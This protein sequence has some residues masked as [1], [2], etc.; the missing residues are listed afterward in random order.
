MLALSFTSKTPEHKGIVESTAAIIFLGTPHRGSPELSAIGEWARSMLSTLHFQTATAMLDTLGLKTTDLERAHEAFCRIWHQYDFQVKTFQESLGLTG[1]DLGVLGNKVVPHESSLIGDPREQA[2]TLQANHLQMCRFSRAQDPNYIKVAGE[3]RRFYIAIQN[4]QLKYPGGTK[5]SSDVSNIG[6]TPNTPL[7]KKDLNTFLKILHF[8]G[9]NTRRESILPP[10]ANT[11]EWLFHDPTSSQWCTSP[12]AADRLLF[13]KGKP[14]AGKSTLMKK[15]VRHIQAVLE[16]GI[17]ASFFVDA[18]GLPLQHSPKGIYQSLLCQ[19]L[20]L[21][22]IWTAS[23][24]SPALRYLTDTIRMALDDPSV[25]STEGQLQTL[26][27]DTLEV[28]SSTSTPI[29][30]F[31]DALDELELMQRHQIEFWRG[32]VFSTKSQTLRVCLSCRHFPNVAVN[33]CLELVLD[34]CNSQDIFTYTKDRLESHVSQSEPHW[35]RL[36]EKR[37]TSLASGVFL[38]VV[39]VL[40]DILAKYDQGISLQALMRHVEWMPTELEK[41]YTRILG[42]LAPN[43]GQLAEKVFQ[44]VFASTRPLR[45]DEWHHI[46]A[47]MRPSRPLSLQEWRESDDFTESDE[48]LERKIKTL[49]KGLLEVSHKLSEASNGKFAEDSSVNAGA[50]SLD[51]EQG[52]S[53]VV[54]AIHQSVYDFFIHNQGFALFGS[55]SAN[56]L[57]DCHCTIANTCLNY[58]LIPELD[59]YV[60]ARQRIKMASVA[61]SSVPSLTPPQ[62]PRKANSSQRNREVDNII[63]D[64]EQ[65]LSLDSVQIVENWLAGGDIP[66][67]TE[68]ALCPTSYC[69]SRDSIGVVSRALEDYPALLIYSITELPCHIDFALT[70]SPNGN[71]AQL[72]LRLEDKGFGERLVALQQGKRDRDHIIYFLENL[73]LHKPRLDQVL[74]TQF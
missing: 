42:D 65:T 70:N 63:E 2:E 21:R 4:A 6:S 48:Q 11:T 25:V 33:G 8:D 53:R 54:K 40:D 31:L 28:L 51:H 68:N 23:P 57:T 20:P 62:Q 50:G 52:S 10:S 30:I 9:I 13:I 56:P 49:S 7:D 29:W 66:S 69:A 15:A 64:L 24:D 60:I 41:L 38:W 67:Y 18:G 61:T 47:F 55:D 74:Q 37:I 58:I 45:L 1:I 36:L 32:L 46:L 39:L 34:A 5:P 73:A 17:C 12:K 44:W 26:L 19:L 16:R 27:T 59:E 14:G 3:L 71:S 22:K 35:R 72:Q 43:E